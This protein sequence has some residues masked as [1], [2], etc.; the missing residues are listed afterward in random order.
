M[1]EH[2][3]TTD[4]NYCKVRDHCHYVGKYTNAAYSIFNLKYSI[5]KETPV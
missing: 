2:K 5:P 1:F 4:K 3:Y